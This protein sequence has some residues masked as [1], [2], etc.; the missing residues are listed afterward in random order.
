[1]KYPKEIIL[2]HFLK[3]YLAIRANPSGLFESAKNSWASATGKNTSI[4]NLQSLEQGLNINYRL[5]NNQPTPEE[6][7]KKWVE[8]LI[9]LGEN[10]FILQRDSRIVSNSCRTLHASRSYVLLTLMASDEGTEAINN[11]ITELNDALDIIQKTKDA[12]RQ[13]AP[14]ITS[15]TQI[16]D[17]DYNKTLRNLAYLNVFKVT[18][19]V[20]LSKHFPTLVFPPEINSNVLPTLSNKHK[21]QINQN[22]PYVLHKEYVIIY[23]NNVDKPNSPYSEL[24]LHAFE[25]RTL[26]EFAEQNGLVYPLHLLHP[27]PQVGISNEKKSSRLLDESKSVTQK[28]NGITTKNGS[29]HLL[30]NHFPVPPTNSTS[31]LTDQNL[32]QNSHDDN[33][34]PPRTAQTGLNP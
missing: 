12:I 32:P 21:L 3:D 11:K 6:A 8:Q 26:Q 24:S 29:E 33:T 31:S 2:K 14:D 18:D 5:A 1:V 13:D 30:F 27:D 9:E 23:I 19:K 4:D 7:A 16:C 15:R 22:I 20:Q 17:N 34:A 28:Q 10:A 25:E